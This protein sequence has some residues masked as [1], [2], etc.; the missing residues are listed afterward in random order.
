MSDSTPNHHELLTN[1]IYAERRE[2]SA[3]YD[4]LREI[5]FEHLT[6]EAELDRASE[7]LRALREALELVEVLRRLVRRTP[8]VV[9]IHQAF[10]APGDFGYYT[11]IGA[12]LAR[13]YGVL[14][15]PDTRGAA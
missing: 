14:S 2:Y 6:S 10:G 1:A 12:A 9:I 15:A 3:A 4:K 7:A 11:P 5:A 8:D 13:V